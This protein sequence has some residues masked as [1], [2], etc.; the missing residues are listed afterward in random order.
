MK[1]M[2]D[3]TFGQENRKK[4]ARLMRHEVVEDDQSVAVANE[5]Q[6]ISDAAKESAK[7]IQDYLNKGEEA[8]MD[9]PLKDQQ[10]KAEAGKLK[11]DMVNHP[12][13]YTAG[14][15]ECIDALE[16]MSVGYQD[17]IQAALAWQVVKYIWR[18]PLKGKQLE[19]L[20]K[21]QFYLNRLIEKVKHEDQT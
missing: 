3:E 8:N 16:S 14:S 19:D 12:A 2:R 5:I 9:K 1:F 11:I 21:A 15:V 17:T 4:A 6:K 18:S 7:I 20:Q 10:A 13:H